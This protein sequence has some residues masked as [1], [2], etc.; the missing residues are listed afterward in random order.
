MEGDVAGGVVVAVVGV[1]GCLVLA[2]LLGL[3]AGVAILVASTAAILAGALLTVGG[4]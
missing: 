1:G 3:P 2:H 4:R